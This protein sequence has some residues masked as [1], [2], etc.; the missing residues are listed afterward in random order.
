MIKVICVVAAALVALKLMGW[1]SW[2]WLW[3]LA[4]LWL[5]LALVM[6]IMAVVLMVTL[7]KGEEKQ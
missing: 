4:P 1:L 6:G 2:G 3:V 7:C 5:P